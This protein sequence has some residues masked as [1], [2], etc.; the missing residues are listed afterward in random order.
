AHDQ[1]CPLSGSKPPW[2]RIEATL[3]PDRSHLGAGS[4]PLSIS[5][6]SH[7]RFGS[8]PLLGPDRSHFGAKKLVGRVALLWGYR[9]FSMGRMPVGIPL[10]LPAAAQGSQVTHL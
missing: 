1:A 2:R 7:C 10:V 8:K 4:K 6:R 3:A 5:D 9:L